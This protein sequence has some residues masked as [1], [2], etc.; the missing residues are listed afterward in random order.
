MCTVKLRGSHFGRIDKSVVN[1]VLS[2]TKELE[3]DK[4]YLC[5]PEDMIN[6]VSAVLKEK[7]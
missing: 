2:N 6:T 3:F 1:F 7:M 4:F 5:G